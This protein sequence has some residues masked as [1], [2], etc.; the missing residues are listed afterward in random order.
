MSKS[1]TISANCTK[2]EFLSTVRINGLLESNMDK[3]A[4]KLKVPDI[5]IVRVARDENHVIIGGALGSTYLSSFEVE[6]LWVDDAYRGQQIATRLLAE[7]EAEAKA[8]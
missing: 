6:V 3:T 5:E 4:G 7:I 2:A 8:A 1:I